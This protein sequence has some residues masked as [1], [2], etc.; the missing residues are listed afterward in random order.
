MGWCRFFGPAECNFRGVY[1]Q[2][3]KHHNTPKMAQKHQPKEARTRA[4]LQND[5]GRSAVEICKEVRPENI[6]SD[7]E[8]E[9]IAETVQGFMAD[10]KIGA[11]YIDPACPWQN[12]VI[13]SF[14][15]RLRREF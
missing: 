14:N 13:E 6:R 10:H 8:S 3:Q 2:T 7:N 12:G 9:F 5:G 15:L 1:N 4:V 11:I